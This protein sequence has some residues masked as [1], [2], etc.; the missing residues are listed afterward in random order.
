MK[1]DQLTIA[2][3][4]TETSPVTF[5]TLLNDSFEHKTGSVGTVLPHTEAK[6]IG[7]DGKILSRNEK[8]EVLT[9]GYC[10]MKGYWGD[11]KATKGSID[12]DGWMHTGDVGI[13][14]DEGYLNIVGRIKDMI[15]RGGENVY[16]KEIEEYLLKNENVE[17]AQVF[18]FPDEK[19]GEEIFAWIKIKEGKTMKKEDVFS[20]CKGKIAHYKVPKYVKFVDDFPITVTGKP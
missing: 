9:R 1:I 8:G 12:E 5:Q 2:Y 6:I 13:V 7:E 18:G 16:P 15:I 17:N 20:Y 4:M 19:M 3:G 11:E 10:V 14:D